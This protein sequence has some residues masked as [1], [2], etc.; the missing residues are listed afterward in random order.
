MTPLVLLCALVAASPEFEA[1]N[2]AGRA[3]SGSLSE[4]TA[5]KVVLKTAG[6]ETSLR[7]D[8]LLTLTPKETP[9]D[10]DFT[11]TVWIELIDGST[12]RGV[13]Y[14]SAK[15]TSRLKITDADK[16]ELP[17]KSLRFVRFS[18]PDETLDA[19]WAKAL[20][21]KTAGDLI[22]VRKKDALDQLEGVVGD[23]TVDKVVFEL[24]HEP[25]DVKRTRVDGLIFARSTRELPDTVCTVEDV[26]GSKLQ[27]KSV[28][29]SDGKLLVVTTAG[30]KIP[31]PLEQVS[32]IDFSAS[33][34]RYLSDLK[35]ESVEWTPFFAFSKEVPELT[36]N[37]KPRADRDLEGGPLRLGGKKYTKG[38]G[39]TSR[40]TIV[41]RVP[42][43]F[44]SFKALAGIDD[45]VRDQ[46]NVRLEIS[47]D[48]NRLLEATLTGK[49][50]P[51]EVNLDLAG[52]KKLT[53]LVDF[54]ED[55]DV[56][57]HVN[58]AEARFTK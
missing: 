11:P 38:L 9:A 14:E 42:A 37:F 8:E 19:Q 28:E 46:G 57:D 12:L 17:T 15:G 44:R 21:A 23:V 2:T 45:A 51:R 50:E 6:G 18:A 16:V 33:S 22:V 34:I 47:G 24:D 32:R 56:A 49:D 10:V 27:A 52:V 3:V 36:E 35:P 41:Y 26:T 4:L 55:S 13:A 25:I 43:G 5:E 31:R 53:I 30:A 39:L 1:A 40:T 54:G 7:R 58:L 29:L 48:G 20:E